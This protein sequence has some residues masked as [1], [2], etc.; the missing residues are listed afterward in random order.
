MVCIKDFI[1]V[2]TGFFE[3]LCMGAIFYGWSS[4]NYILTREGYFNSSC[5]ETIHVSNNFTSSICPKQQYFLELAFTLAAAVPPGLCLVIGIFFDV[6]GTWVLRTFSSILYI[7]SC[8]AIA[9]SSS[10][11]SWIIY[12]ATIS[13][14][15][16]GYVALISNGQTANLFA[17]NRGFI[18][19]VLGGSLNGSLA[20]LTLVK[21][22]YDHGYSLKWS[23][24]LL[25]ALGPF[26]LVR[27]FFLMPKSVIPSKVPEDYYYGIKE[28]CDNIKSSEESPLLA[29]ESSNIENV[30]N[31]PTIKSYILSPLYLL[32]VFSFSIQL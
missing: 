1:S 20:M 3:A 8:V 6:Y 4:F 13:V 27:T 22:A 21:L 5:N 24:L 19:N 10:S 9:Y 26:M 25:S 2:T 15:V 16:C 29:S 11:Y 32:G 12:P 7:L 17:N 18:T 30:E 28:C 14:G 23:F 31:T